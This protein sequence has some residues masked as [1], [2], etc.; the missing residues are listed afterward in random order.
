M[1]I[2]KLRAVMGPVEPHG[3]RESKGLAANEFTGT[4]Q[5]G[6]PSVSKDLV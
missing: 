6:A 1:Y 3:D 4:K 5:H 2:G